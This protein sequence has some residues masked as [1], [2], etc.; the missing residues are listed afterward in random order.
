MVW[1]NLQAEPILQVTQRSC[2]L[3]VVCRYG[4]VSHD[5]KYEYISVKHLDMDVSS[6]GKR[7]SKQP[8]Q[9]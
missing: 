3:R 9:P 5:S 1:V 2:V 7:N 4:I 6:L 8:H